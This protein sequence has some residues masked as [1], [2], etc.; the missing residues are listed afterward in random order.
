[1]GVFGWS[2][3]EIHAGLIMLASVLLGGTGQATTLVT[4]PCRGSAVVIAPGSRNAP[5]AAS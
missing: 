3:Q 4:D 1:M 2:Q 5:T